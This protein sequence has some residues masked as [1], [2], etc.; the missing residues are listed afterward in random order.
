MASLFHLLFIAATTHAQS[1]F[2]PPVI[3]QCLNL[4]N[5][6]SVVCVNNYASVLPYP[7]IRATASNGSDPENDTFVDTS[8]PSDNSFAKVADATFVVFDRERGLDILGPAPKLERI[9]DTRNDSIHEA[10]VYVPG[11]NAIIFSQPHQSVYQQKIINLNG[12]EPTISNYTT[13]PPVYAVNGGKY[14]KGKIYWASEASFSFPSPADGSTVN[15]TPGIYELDPFTGEVRTLLNNYYGQQLSS[16][17]DLIIDSRGDIFFTDS[18]YGYAI[19]VTTYPVLSPQTFRFRP[20]TGAVSVVENSLEQPNGIGISPDGKTMYISDTGITD[21][22]G[23]APDAPPPRY[24][25]NKF[26]GRTVYA[27]DINFAPPGNYLTNKR[28][29]WLAQTFAVDGLHV[30]REGYVL[31][32]SGSGLDILSEWGELLLRIEVGG[33][34]NNFQFAGPER[35]ELWLFGPSG[36]WKVSGLKGLR[37]LENE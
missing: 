22:E 10:P 29:I 30:S 14:Y 6:S 7:F 2:A 24:T 32:A 12:T 25:F 1:G 15:Q 33:E 31:G 28:P 35:R 5:D 20:S 34:I 9:F 8:V 13:T 18:W 17:N 3:E 26:G 4:A 36:I 21:F 19:N 27:F 11:L 37:G 16:P 23:V